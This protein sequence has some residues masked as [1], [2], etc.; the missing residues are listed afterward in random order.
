MPPYSLQERFATE[1]LSSALGIYLALGVITNNLFAREDGGSYGFGFVSLGFGLAFSV[2]LTMFDFASAHMN[3]AMCIA[4]WINGTIDWR[5][6]LV[7]SAGEYV[8]MFAGALLVWVHYWPHFSLAPGDDEAPAT[9]E[10]IDNDS[11]KKLACF[12]APHPPPVDVHWFHSFFVEFLS[13]TVLVVAVLLVY[14]RHV[15]IENSDAKTA[16]GSTG[17]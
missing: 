9:T 14:S 15:Q 13:T 4:L 2:P 7:A 17:R 1:V 3:P 8:G 6:F 16:R 12:A 10:E 11:K 5:E